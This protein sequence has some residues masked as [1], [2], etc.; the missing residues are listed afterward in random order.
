MIEIRKV[1]A[2][3]AYPRN[4]NAH[5]PTPRYRWEVWADGKRV[6][7]ATSRKSAEGLAETQQQ[8]QLDT[9]TRCGGTGGIW[10]GVP[11]TSINEPCPDCSV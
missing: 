7:S 4:G 2:G 9:C 5:N 11:G 1:V 3:Y 8:Q 10:L 6:G